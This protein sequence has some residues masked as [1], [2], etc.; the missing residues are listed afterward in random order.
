MVEIGSSGIQSR[1]RGEEGI[2]Q[3]THRKIV[4]LRQVHLHFG[5][6][7]PAPYAVTVGAGGQFGI[8]GQVVFTLQRVHEPR[9][10]GADGA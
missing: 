4:I 2:H 1:M 6:V 7:A 5:K 3:E 8:N 10:A 9:L